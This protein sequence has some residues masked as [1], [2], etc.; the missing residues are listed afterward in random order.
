MGLPKRWIEPMS[1]KQFALRSGLR[2]WREVE[3]GTFEGGDLML[4]RPGLALI[5]CSGDRTTQSAADDLTS[6]F[7]RKDWACR[8][9]T[10]LPKYR[11]L[12]L[13]VGIL[14]VSNLLCHVQALA[15]E[16]VRWLEQAGYT[17]HAVDDDEVWRM[18]CNI[19]NVGNRTVIAAQECPKTNA[20]MR[21]LGFRVLEVD[22]ASF[23]DDLGGVHCLTQ[24][25]QRAKSETDRRMPKAV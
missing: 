6:W 8:T 19:L 14:D 15:P 4:L 9:I 10:Y 11:H 2:I 23:A 7:A 3:R 25:L 17:L 24:G 16:A 5:G 13:V 20:L 21:S 18:G 12:D 1:V 22:I